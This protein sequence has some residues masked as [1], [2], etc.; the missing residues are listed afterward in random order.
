MGQSIVQTV[1]SVIILA[2]RV[3]KI[4][5]ETTSSYE[6]IQFSNCD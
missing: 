4:Q 6:H 1:Y 5:T 3:Q 2:Q